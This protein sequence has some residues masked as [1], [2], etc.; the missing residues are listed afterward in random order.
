MKLKELKEV[1]TSIVSLV[2]NAVNAKRVIKEREIS[3]PRHDFRCTKTWEQLVSSLRGEVK[4]VPTVTP[5]KLSIVRNEEQIRHQKLLDKLAEEEKYFVIDHHGVKLYYDVNG[6][7]DS[8]GHPKM[9][10]SWDPLTEDYEFFWWSDRFQLYLHPCEEREL[11]HHAEVKA[12]REAGRRDSARSRK[13]NSLSSADKAKFT[14]IK[15]GQ[16]A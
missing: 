13:F 9:L 8:E 15:G 14:V 2:A 5:V 4:S 10:K 6:E 1:F 11:I 16:N 3:I 12:A 7:F